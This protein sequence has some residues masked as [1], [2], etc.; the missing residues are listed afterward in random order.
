MGGGFGFPNKILESPRFLGYWWY[1]FTHWI[2]RQ[3]E[4]SIQPLLMSP[5]RKEGYKP[6]S[7]QKSGSLCSDD[8]DGDDLHDVSILD[9]SNATTLGRRAVL[10]KIWAYLSTVMNVFMAL[11]LVLLYRKLQNLSSPLPPWPDTVYCQYESRSIQ[12]ASSTLR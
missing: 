2:S 8:D 7:E 12:V 10:L 1:E 6:L 9:N 11:C 4:R 3:V 5:G